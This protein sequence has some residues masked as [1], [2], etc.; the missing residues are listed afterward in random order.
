[1]SAILLEGRS[2]ADAIKAELRQAIEVLAAS[3]VRPGLGVLLAGDDPASAVYVRSK[4]L[5]CDALGIHHETARLP[6]SATT[7]AVADRVMEYNRRADIHGIL[8]QLPLPPQV[9]A[10][11]I[12]RLVDPEKDVDGFH[13]ENLGLLVQKQPRFVAC[14]PAG[15]LELLTRQGVALAGRRAVVL[16]RSDIVGKPMALL[17]LHADATVTICH[18][19]TRE[20]A[21][22]TRDAD[23]LVVAMGKPGFVRPEHVKP[24]AVVVDVG[25][26]RIEDAARAETLVEPSRMDSF[27]RRG[28]VVVGDVHFSVRD[29]AGALTPVPGGVG[30]LTIAL[31]MSNTV[32]AARMRLDAG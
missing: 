23:V 6:Q 12:L 31:L 29:T 3:G 8:V 5:A 26:N 10:P 24:G 9:D 7:Q 17:L 21:S 20:L 18:S 19:R 15:I 14:T 2:T 22:L 28:H 13:P 11:A 30:P 32:K 16:G 25:I 27:V 1:V 4:T